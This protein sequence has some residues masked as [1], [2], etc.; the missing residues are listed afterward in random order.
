MLEIYR[1]L[2]GPQ[3]QLEHLY[4]RDGFG[5]VIVDRETGRPAYDDRN[6]WNSTTTLG[7]VHLICNQNSLLAEVYLAG[8]STILRKT[9]DG[10]PITDQNEL[11][12]CGTSVVFGRNSDP[13]IS[14]H[15]NDLVRSNLRISLNNPVGLYLQEPAFER[16]QLPLH[17]PA[18][19]K[20][21]ANG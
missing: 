6:G 21:S 8:Q 12:N 5:R 13:T 15:V 9:R 3:V 7:V 14:V 10:R 18:G 2:I 1:E 16:F 19:A 11:L 17:A 20:P 4:L